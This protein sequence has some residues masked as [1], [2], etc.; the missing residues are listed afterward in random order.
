MLGMELNKI[1]EESIKGMQAAAD[2]LGLRGE[3]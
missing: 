2:D 3:L 1:I